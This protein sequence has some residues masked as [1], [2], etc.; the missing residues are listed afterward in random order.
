MINKLVGFVLLI[1]AVQ[2]SI[3]KRIPYAHG[4][5]QSP[6]LGNWAYLISG[7]IFLYA[8]YILYIVFYKK[9]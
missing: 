4:G 7:F 3:T 9:K 2:I 6:S 5:V 1:L 8:I